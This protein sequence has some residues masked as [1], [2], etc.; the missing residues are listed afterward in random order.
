MSELIRRRVQ[1]NPL[2]FSTGNTRRTPGLH[3]T[4]IIKAMLSEAGVMEKYK[5]EEDGGRS[6]ED[7]QQ[8]A[9]EGYMWED[10]FM[11]I[12]AGRILKR[13]GYIRLP[14]IA[15]HP[16]LRHAF[17][18][19]YDDR[20]GELLTP[21]PRGYVILTPDGGRIESSRFSLV[22][23][24]RWSKS[25]KADPEKH[26][27]EWFYQVRGYMGAISDLIGS[28]V[29]RVEWH[30]HFPVG[31]FWGDRPIYEEWERE[32]SLQESLDTWSSLYGHAQWVV[33][34][35]PDHEWSRWL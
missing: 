6:E 18:V 23:F 7:L 24:K 20:T 22:E 32:Y 5:S 3:L 12:V 1:L 33:K 30:V 4:N 2:D 34:K 25:A 8:F 31:E 16:R 13:P 11:E 19:E 29:T 10:V 14:E 17:Q 26:R 21:I 9:A 15:Y 27:P 28:E 35:N